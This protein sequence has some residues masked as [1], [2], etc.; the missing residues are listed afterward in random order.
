MDFHKRVQR[1]FTRNHLQDIS[2]VRSYDPESG[3]FWCVGDDKRSFLSFAFLCNSL[4]G[5]SS[6]TDE[7]LKT[8]Y[9]SEFPADTLATISCISS[10]NVK[11][12]IMAYARSRAN[13]MY[14]ETNPKRAEFARN[15]VRERVKLFM[16]GQTNPMDTTSEN[17]LKD[18]YCLITFQIP[19]S[20]S[21]TEEDFNQLRSM[22]LSIKAQFD[23]IRMYPT[24]VDHELYI[25]LMRSI[26]YFGE[27]RP[28]KMDINAEINQQ[29]FDVDTDMEIHKDHL[30]INDKYFRVMSVEQYPQQT[31]LPEVGSLLGCPK[32]TKNQITC[33]FIINTIIYFPDRHKEKQRITK[34]AAAINVQARGKFGQMVRR[35]GLKDEQYQLL[36]ESI[37]NAHRPVRVWTSITLMTDDFDN[38]TKQTSQVKGYWSTLG[39]RVNVDTYMQG[40]LFQQILPLCSCPDVVDFTK[41]YNSMT[42]NEVVHLLPLVADWGG[43]GDTATSMFYSR[44]G[45]IILYSNYD[46]DVSMNVLVIGESGSGKSF[47]IADMIA[48]SYAQGMLI[49]IIDSGRSFLNLVNMLGGEFIEF[50]PEAD[51]CINP[52]TNI[53]DINQELSALKVVLEQICAPKQGLSD[54]QLAKLEEIVL[55]LFNAYGNDMDI[56]LLSDRII[57][58]GEKNNDEQVRRLGWQFTPF[59][60]HGSFGRWFTGKANLSFSGDVSA[61]ELDDLGSMVELRTVTLLL[62]IMQLQRDFINGDR[63]IRK[64]LVI[65]EY[66]RFGIGT[67]PGSMRVSE[68]IEQAFRVMRKANGSVCLGTQS[69]LDIAPKGHSPLIDNAATV[70]LMKQKQE[71]LEAI[72]EHKLLNISDQDFEMLSTLTKGSGYSDCFMY[73]S[74]RGWGFARFVVDRFS[75][76]LYSTS[77][78]E[79]MRIKELRQTGL[80]VTEAIHAYIDQYDG[81]TVSE[82]APSKSA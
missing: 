48:G 25:S 1:L 78:V 81:S 9:D 67:D 77:P 42:I 62:M 60:R 21:P 41:R 46:S 4:P 23:T 59:C 39:Y 49:R 32:G 3:V 69:L 51:I 74:T 61:L 14:D 36:T 8:I 57:S 20:A 24:V 75:Q 64:L 72:K 63:R 38:L 29:I 73:T 34:E 82:D 65:D 79:F 55:E 6:G 47:Q 13:V 11:H 2:P 19:C 52:F 31:V 40:P 58:Y 22:Q 70:I 18:V 28:M 10:N 27:E 16:D 12:K 44:R 80:T 50:H 45:Q 30:R 71:T 56:T 35:I 43:P 5:V 15:M 68:F 76:L 54:Y 17:L 26:V 33:S 53:Q 7:T 66:W 37:E